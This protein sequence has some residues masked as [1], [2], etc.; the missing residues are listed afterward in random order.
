MACDPTV[1]E[2]N[3]QWAC[4]PGNIGN[5]EAF[6]AIVT[7]VD[8][9]K[10]TGEVVLLFDNGAGGK[11]PV[12][13]NWGSLDQMFTACPSEI[14]PANSFSSLT[15]PPALHAEGK[16]MMRASFLDS[17][18]VPYSSPPKW[19]KYLIG[20]FYA[21]LAIIPS[22]FELYG[23]EQETIDE[24][25]GKVDLYDAALAK[26]EQT[27]TTDGLTMTVLLTPNGFKQFSVEFPALSNLDDAEAVIAE[28]ND[29]VA[30]AAAWQVVAEAARQVRTPDAAG[31]KKVPPALKR[32][33]PKL[34]PS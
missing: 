34:F 14:A 31:L 18:G 21:P 28:Q 32:L 20:T 8:A 24:S 19:P 15:K 27:F 22:S 16:L 33:L 12:V 9:I 6:V 29:P 7:K 10:A 5:V 4:K 1:S 25:S 30:I 26:P 17:K 3:R 23:N 2:A 11:M 13:T